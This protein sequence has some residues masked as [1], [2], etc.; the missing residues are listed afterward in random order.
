MAKFNGVDIGPVQL[1][2]GNMVTTR[3]LYAFAESQLDSAT[4]KEIV[5]AL[6]GSSDG[7]KVKVDEGGGSGS[8]YWNEGNNIA[9]KRILKMFSFEAIV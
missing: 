9:K 3:S 7:R 2:A 6:G 4:D 5:K 8:F 1:K